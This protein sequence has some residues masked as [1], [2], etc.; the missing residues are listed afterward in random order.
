MEMCVSF[1]SVRKGLRVVG[2]SLQFHVTPSLIMAREGNERTLLSQKT[3]SSIKIFHGI[4]FKQK[5]H[6]LWQSQLR[7][8][9]FGCQTLNRY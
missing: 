7:I 3:P 6:K 4:I 1:T 8:T 5:G 9:F 2:C